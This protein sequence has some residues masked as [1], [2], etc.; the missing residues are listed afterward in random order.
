MIILTLNP[1]TNPSLRTFEKNHLVI[2]SAKEPNHNVD[3]S[4]GEEGLLAEHL[5][6]QW[7]DGRYLIFNYANDPFITIN[8]Q[9]FGKK[10]L[11][12]GDMIGI[13]NTE[14]LFD[15]KETPDNLSH[16]FEQIKNDSDNEVSIDNTAEATLSKDFDIEELVRQTE[17]LSAPDKIM[18]SLF[19]KNSKTDWF[20]NDDEDEKDKTEETRLDNIE[21]LFENEKKSEIA[22]TFQSQEIVF[23]FEEPQESEASSSSE[24][25]HSTVVDADEPIQ[26]R[27]PVEE[28]NLSKD[29]RDFQGMQDSQN[30]MITPPRDISKLWKIFVFATIALMV[31]IAITV[32]YLMINEQTDIHEIHAAQGVSD[33]AMAITY[34]QL[35]HIKPPNQNWSDHDFIQDNLNAILSSK[36]TPLSEVDIQGQ[37]HDSPYILRIYTSRDSSQFLVIA[38]PVPSL[39]HWLLPK[40]AI[41]VDSHN[42][43]IRKT[44][45]LRTLNRL[46]VDPNT[47]D[48]SNTPEISNLVHQGEILPLTALTAD[49]EHPE[50]NP[51]KELAYIR[52]GSENLIYNAPR[53][54]LFSKPI[55]DKVEQL[56]KYPDN[57]QNIAPLLQDIAMFS[58]LHDMVLYSAGGMD[59]AMQVQKGLVPYAPTQGFLVGYLS[60]NSKTDLIN[61]SHLILVANHFSKKLNSS[62]SLTMPSPN[63]GATEIPQDLTSVG[64]NIH[65]PLFTHLSTLSIDRRKKLRGVSEQLVGLLALHTQRTVPNFNE[66]FDELVNQYKRTNQ[67]LHVYSEGALLQLYHD[68]VAEGPKLTPTLFLAYVEA[69]GLGVF[70][71][72]NPKVQ[73]TIQQHGMNPEQIFQKLNSNIMQA[74]DLITLDQAVEDAASMLSQDKQINS[75]NLTSLQNQLRISVMQKL[76]HFLLFPSNNLPQDTFTEKN[77]WILLR[78]LKNG[79]VTDPDEREFYIS[80]FDSLSK[81]NARRQ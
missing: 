8:D 2:G 15:F 17:E 66:H 23:K 35:H 74:K 27:M 20:A 54:Y 62:T 44:K 76:E 80:Q 69:S 70:A 60:F 72:N 19:E 71:Q 58:K 1:K 55:I 4:L 31:C 75:E 81:G 30:T 65:H 6:I 29:N 36:Y 3:L 41:I 5:K 48:S 42:M 26:A 50:F 49:R 14:I 33:I 59:G 24:S 64:I 79:R 12:R 61:G 46:L 11:K 22:D 51:P 45:D 78:I 32:S 40:K 63:K 37:F 77:R 16:T 38:Q 34:A 57:S 18:D 25:G 68:Y 52:P 56:N 13:G 43:E 53:Y 7:I 67:E 47:L 21:N 28:G 73:A 10:V 39:L 9:P